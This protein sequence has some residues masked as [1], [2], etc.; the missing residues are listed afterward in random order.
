MQLWD[1]NDREPVDCPPVLDDYDFWLASLSR[2]RRE[3]YVR[4]IETI[5]IIANMVRRRKLTGAQNGPA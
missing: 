1:I 5:Q 4:C 2:R 3:Q